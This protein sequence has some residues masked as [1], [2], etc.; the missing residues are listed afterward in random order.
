M[1]HCAIGLLDLELIFEIVLN[2]RRSRDHSVVTES[3][4]GAGPILNF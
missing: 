1:F 2:G 3:S 4:G